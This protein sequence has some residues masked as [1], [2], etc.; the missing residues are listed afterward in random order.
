MGYSAWR[1]LLRAWVGSV[2][3]AGG[4]SAQPMPGPGEEL[5]RT[6]GPVYR[7]YPPFFEASDRVATFALWQAF[8]RAK[9]AGDEV[10]IIP[11][12][13]RTKDGKTVVRVPIEAGTSLYGT[14]MVTGPLLRNG[15]KVVAWNSDR[16]GYAPDADSLYQSHPWVLGVRAD[17]TAFGVLV[18]TT[19]RATIDLSDG[20]VVTCEGK[21][22]PVYVMS[23][24]TP[25]DVLVALRELTGNMSMPPR[26][27]LG[28]QQC[29]WSYF[30]EAR[31]REVAG[32][33]RK[34][35]IPADV[36]WFDIDYMD[37]FRV[38]TFDK[39]H[40]PDP[41]KLNADL[42]AQ[43]WKRV[44]MINPGVK[45]EPGF[46]VREQL[47]AGGFFVKNPDGSPFRGDVWPGSCLFPDFT[48]PAARAWFGSLYNDFMAVGVDGVWNDMNEPAVFG[49]PTKVM[50]E[51]AVHKGGEYRSFSGVPAQVVTPGDHARFHN[52]YGMLMA[53]A[54]REGILKAQPGK[55]PFVLSR[56]NYLGGQRYAAAWTGDNSANWTDL[57]Q[58]VPMVLSLGL[59]GQ[60][61]SGPDIG[62]FAGNGPRDTAEKADQFARWMGIGALMPFARGHTA[63]GN[64]NKEPWEFGAETERAS[65]L[66]IERR[67]R[68][69]PYYYTLFYEASTRGIPVVRP[70]FFADPKDPA[71]RSEDDSFLIGKNVLVEP[72]LMPDRTRVTIKPKGIWRKFDV[73]DEQ[74]PANPD[75]YLR[76]G[77]IVPLGPAEQ[78]EAE[79]PLD[80]LTLL[81]SL[82]ESGKA[83]GLLY[84]D[85]GDGWGFLSG[86]LLFSKYVAERQ[87]DEVVVKLEGAQGRMARPAR[88][89]IVRVVMDD[90]VAEGRGKD[91]EVVRVK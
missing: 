26:W 44:W 55:R 22:P 25:E 73:V 43:G 42:G 87:G 39:G 11:E 36:F 77:A 91:G 49:S 66:A 83:E 78:F 30:P 82:D 35:K 1:W 37:G 56:A 84:E 33:F 40:F 9:P 14:G 16:P 6:S 20:I 80:P 71:L 72:Q 89:L 38:F 64:M 86:E 19:W 70:V 53:Q 60:P 47:L 62:G 17:G 13:D 52:V 85:A 76:G 15:R 28:Y 29:R 34:R 48:D 81:V 5:D 67:Y 4:A 51:N 3:L 12:F 21:P 32:E 61:F 45:D 50:P 79:K 18:D 31:V 54:T 46:F 58:S 63:K 75:L 65:R 2:L 57:E 90:R 7:F 8:E 23:R 24:A 74:H 68:L 88:E 27:A 41:A 59:S 10:Q 69:L